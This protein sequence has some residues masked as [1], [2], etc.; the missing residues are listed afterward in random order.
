MNFDK[1]LHALHTMT[2]I[3][4]CG[5][6]KKIIGLVVEGSGPR[7]PLGGMCEINSPYQVPVKA[8]VI[9][10]RENSVLMMPLGKLQGIKQGNIIRTLA[11]E[12]SVKAGPQLLGR[13][14]DALGNPIDGRGK[15][16]TETKYPF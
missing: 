12:D 7:I 6:V 16:Y 9:G 1:Y 14:I 11:F 15:I 8:E 10:F 2:P 3:T 4:L 13:V 5:E